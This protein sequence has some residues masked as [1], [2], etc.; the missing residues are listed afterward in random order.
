MRVLGI[1]SDNKYVIFDPLNKDV[2]V[3]CLDTGEL[4][5]TFN[6][7]PRWDNDYKI[8]ATPDCQYLVSVE[9]CCNTGRPANYIRV[10]SLYDDKPIHRLSLPAAN[11]TSMCVTPDNKHLVIGTRNG[12]LRINRLDNGKLLHSTQSANDSITK[13]CVTLDNKYV[14]Y[15]K[16]FGN[17]MVV[18]SLDTGKWIRVING[19]KDMV[20]AICMTPDNKYVVSGSKDKTVRI[21]RLDNGKLVCVMEGHTGWVSSVC[22]T[23]DNKYVVSGSSDMTIRITR[24]LDGML[25]QEIF[26][27]KWVRS[28]CTSQE[29]YRIIVG[30]LWE[31]PV[32]LDT[33][34][35]LH[36]RQWAQVMLESRKLPLFRE[37]PGLLRYIGTKLLLY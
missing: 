21:S 2:Y 25:I 26:I 18:T 11:V 5:C 14:I 34:W 1:R 35:Y 9:K 4:N 22:V 10:T 3:Y 23:P 31:E 27:G 6:D 20:Q 17:S 19:H 37:Y 29:G 30:M 7:N 16:I 28:V 15:A 33:I 8:C 13:L 32:V 12:A 24:L 36:K